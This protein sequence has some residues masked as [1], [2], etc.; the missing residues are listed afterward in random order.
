MVTSNV[1][2]VEDLTIKKKNC[3]TRICSFLLGAVQSVKC[4]PYTLASAES[5]DSFSCV[6]YTSSTERSESTLVCSVAD[7]APTGGLRAEL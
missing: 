7:Q 3:G 5:T 1:P 6:A 2:E 4:H